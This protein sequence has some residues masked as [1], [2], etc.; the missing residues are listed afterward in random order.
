MEQK[1]L[2]KILSL[3]HKGFVRLDSDED[4]TEQMNKVKAG[5]KMLD[6]DIDALKNRKKTGSQETGENETENHHENATDKSLH[7]PFSDCDRTCDSRQKLLLHLLMNHYEEQIIQEFGEGESNRRKLSNL[8]LITFVAFGNNHGECLICNKRLP[9]NLTGYMK[10][11]GVDHE[12]VIEY[13]SKDPSLDNIN[14]DIYQR[15]VKHQD[16][17]GSK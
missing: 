16:A 17:Y 1:L 5:L 9:C 12:V 10:H 6:I 7:C 8:K 4:T 3:V 14:L 15:N 11:I 2:Q 13:M